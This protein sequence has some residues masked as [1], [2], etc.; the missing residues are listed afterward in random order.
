MQGKAGNFPAE[1][2]SLATVTTTIYKLL[3]LQCFFAFYNR[4]IVGGIFA[5]EL[6]REREV[7][8]QTAPLRA[9]VC[10]FSLAVFEK[11]ALRA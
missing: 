10:A 4:R 7:A 1:T 5:H 3:F 6:V 8:V 9:R 2:R 11:L